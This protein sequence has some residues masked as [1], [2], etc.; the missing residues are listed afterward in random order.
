VSPTR[1]FI[2]LGANLGDREA[3]IRHA[4]LLL[5][6]TPGCRVTRVSRLRETRPVGGPPQAD[7]LNGVAELATTLE[8]RALLAT[9]QDLERRAGRRAPRE[10]DG[11]RPLD[12]DLLLFGDAR[13]RE[14]DLVV[15]HPRI[16]ERA[17]VLEPLREL[18]VP[19]EGSAPPSG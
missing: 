5:D 19:W 11:P 2:G 3:A 10:R 6:R 16:G 12:L 14:P 1:A 9:L 13:I 15:P 4:L 7:F 17:F 8:P 18:G